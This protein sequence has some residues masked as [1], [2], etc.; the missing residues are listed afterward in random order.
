MALDKRVE[1]EM[2]KGRAEEKMAQYQRKIRLA[3]QER[4]RLWPQSRCF[5][6]LKNWRLQSKRMRVVGG[7]ED[8]LVEIR[9]SREGMEMFGSKFGGPGGTMS[10][11]EWILIDWAGGI[12]DGGF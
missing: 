12:F 9:V 11:G 2:D 6:G 4:L 7:L 3:E 5:D 10:E 1:K 8:R